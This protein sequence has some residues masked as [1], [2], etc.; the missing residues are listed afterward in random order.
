MIFILSNVALFVSGIM[1]PYCPDK[2]IKPNFNSWLTMKAS[3]FCLYV[4]ALTIGHWMF[5]YEYYNMVRIIPFVLDDI[6]PPESIVKSNRVQYWVWIWISMIFAL[7]S[8]IAKYFWQS[9]YVS[10]SY[11]HPYN[12]EMWKKS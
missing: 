7:L 4:G 10:I 2:S 12:H 3:S 1:N 5:S 9:L 8:G 11:D 6:A